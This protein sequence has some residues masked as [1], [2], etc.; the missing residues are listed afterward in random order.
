MI[1]ILFYLIAIQIQMIQMNFRLLRVPRARGTRKVSENICIICICIA[2]PCHKDAAKR[3]G[4]SVIS[5]FY[6]L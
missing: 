4:D 1:E 3:S 5:H 2:G 6:S